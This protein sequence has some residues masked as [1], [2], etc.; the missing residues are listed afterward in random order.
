MKETIE[1]NRDVRAL[2][3]DLSILE[4]KLQAHYSQMGKHILEAADSEQ[5]AINALVNQ[6]ID[7]KRELSLARNEK[8]CPECMVYNSSDSRYCK[9]CGRPLPDDGEDNDESK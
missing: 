4:A 2:E 1:Q 3:K 7:K 9:Y 5:K 8:Q 6:I